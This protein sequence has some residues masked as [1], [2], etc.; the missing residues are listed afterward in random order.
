MAKTNTEKLK[1]RR[2]VLA[3][4][5]ASLGFSTWSAVETYLKNNIHSP[6]D[7]TIGTGKSQIT[8][9]YRP[10]RAASLPRD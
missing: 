6:M 2:E 10:V 9:K 5:A 3:T 8:Y 1:E 7:L 4:L